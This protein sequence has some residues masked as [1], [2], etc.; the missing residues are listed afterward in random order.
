[1]MK[2]KKRSLLIL[3]AMLLTFIPVKAQA[4]STSPYGYTYDDA[5]TYRT[6]YKYY[7]YDLTKKSYIL[8][9]EFYSKG[10]YVYKS[11][12]VSISNN[13]T[14]SG[15]RYQGFDTEG[16]FYFITKDASISKVDKNYKVTVLNLKNCVKVNYNSVDLAVSVATKSGNFYLSNL[17]PAPETDDDDDNEVPPVIPQKAKNRVDIFTN[18]AG[19]TVYDAYRNGSVKTR[20]IV[21]SNGSKV[22]N[23]TDKVRLSDTLKG[24][25]FLGFDTSYNVYLTEGDTLY[26]FKV[27]KWY[28]AQKMALNGTYKSFK[29]DSNGFISKIVTTKG[30][31]TIKQLTTSSKWKASKTY[32]VSKNTYTTLYIKGSTT[33]HTLSL[34]SGKLT[35]DGK[36]VATN[37]SKFKFVNAKKFAFI[38]K[39][40]NVYTA[41]LANPKKA[42]KVYSGGQSFKTSSGLATKVVTTKGTKKLS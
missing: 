31:Y 11:T 21:S 14:G 13:A 22:L 6:V 30:T 32:A 16:N 1:M 29:K 3:I 20:I 41:T 33:S 23:S 5:A 39:N 26:R 25:K 27:G 15:A 42:K 2:S 19:E 34:I 7:R 40:K 12:G 37:V 10:S 28:S 38:K 35:L 17:K 4:A 8:D 9:R 36:Q 18:S 24:A